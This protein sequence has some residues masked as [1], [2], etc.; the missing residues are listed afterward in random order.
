MTD[1]YYTIKVEGWKYIIDWIDLVKTRNISFKEFCK[2]NRMDYILFSGYVSYMDKMKSDE[3]RLAFVHKQ[4]HRSQCQL[5]DYNNSK[6]N[7]CNC[8]KPKN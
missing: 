7:W 3:E 5:N 4:L 2:N 8:V 6:N 1:P